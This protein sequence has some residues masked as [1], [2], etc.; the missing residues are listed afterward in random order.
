M[1]EIEIAHETFQN[2]QAPSEPDPVGETYDD[3]P[4][5]TVGWGGR[6]LFSPL[7][8]FDCSNWTFV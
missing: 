6:N 2:L 7:D 8:S 3:P 5:Q 1:R 4:I